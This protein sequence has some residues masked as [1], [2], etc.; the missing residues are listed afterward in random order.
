MQLSNPTNVTLSGKARAAARAHI[1]WRWGMVRGVRV[2]RKG[3][4]VPCSCCNVCYFGIFWQSDFDGR[5]DQIVE[6]FGPESMLAVDPSSGLVGGF[7]L[8]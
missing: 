8:D 1:L 4:E 2:G 7:S 3:E 6:C 5:V